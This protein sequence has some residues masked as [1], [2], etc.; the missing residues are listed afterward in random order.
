MASVP[1]AATIPGLA[2]QPSG[3]PD[4]R[5]STPDTLAGTLGKALG[6]TGEAA[7]QLGGA[8]AQ[9]ALRLQMINNQASADTAN[10]AYVKEAEG[11]RAQFEINNKNVDP[12]QAGQLFQ[13]YGT[14]LEGLRQKYRTGLTNVMSQQIFDQ[15]SRRMQNILVGNGA[16]VIAHG[17]DE[18][19]T[20]AYN[21]KQTMLASA[22]A[23]TDN[24]AAQEELKQEAA[25]A[26]VA[27]GKE[28][29]LPDAAIRA[30]TLET[31]TGINTSIIEQ[32]LKTD[33]IKAD[34]YFN[35]YKGEITAKA[36]GDLSEKI[37]TQ[38]YAQVGAKIGD[39][40]AAAASAFSPTGKVEGDAASFYEKGILWAET[41]NG[42]GS[43][44]NATS[45]AEGIG[46]MMPKTAE[47]EAAKLG[48]P[49]KPEL[50]QS[51]APAAIAYQRQLSQAYWNEAVK[52]ENGD[53]YRAAM[54]Y[55]GGS[56]EAQWGPKTKAYA[57]SVVA[58]AAGEGMKLTNLQANMPAAYQSVDDQV[59]A[60]AKTY[61]LNPDI[62]RQAAEG[63]F[64]G[65]VHRQE[66]VYNQAN[67]ATKSSILT[68]IVGDDQHPPVTNLPDLL[69]MPGMSD[70]WHRL[71]QEDRNNLSGVMGR[72]LGQSSAVQMYQIESWKATDPNRFLGTD[73]TSPEYQ[74]EL[75]PQAIKELVNEQYHFRASRERQQ[76]YTVTLSQINQNSLL[77]QSLAS[78][79][80]TDRSGKVL[81][82]DG[83]DTFVGAMFT[84]MRV[85][86]ANNPNVHGPIPPDVL[87]KMGQ[88]ILGRGLVENRGLLSSTGQYVQVHTGEAA[89][90]WEMG[91]R[92]EQYEAARRQLRQA[93]GGREPSGAEISAIV[94]SVF[95]DYK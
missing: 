17:T 78:H 74:K 41:R 90:A 91:E 81:N 35:L 12:S 88:D 14:Q 47:A 72:E 57:A 19:R 42:K 94:R 70:A 77:N 31:T 27:R 66:F 7:Q 65:N 84:E 8:F 60:A 71:T 79:G 49:W 61:N 26:W 55:Y 13:D 37:Q 67:A 43:F 38:L 11:V 62:L 80:L 34:A 51:K 32:L 25:N 39:N 15:D 46:Q 45:G 73:F 75:T 28:L 36:Q 6:Q 10:S 93:H 95:G 2:P 16:S 50:M 53:L 89:T 20:Q 52:A 92:A 5:A 44:L 23:A 87:A 63:K 69:T 4:L 64:E 85:W 83:Y 68:A 1:E 18:F 59:A 24:P 76:N 56:N 48:L 40:A 21:G 82:Q 58:H 86:H 30:G 29:N 9:H 54:Y 22:A 33:A 3:A